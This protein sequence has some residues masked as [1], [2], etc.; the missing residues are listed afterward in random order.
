[1]Y[2]VAMLV[3]VGLIASTVVTVVTDLV[4]AVGKI[5]FLG[6]PDRLFI[7]T[8]VL[9]VWLGDVNILG[10]FGLGSTQEWVNVVGSGLAVAAFASVTQ[11]VTNYLDK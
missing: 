7:L 5:P 3:L 11:S 8:S 1:M 4:P 6:N 2:T 10:A 9:L